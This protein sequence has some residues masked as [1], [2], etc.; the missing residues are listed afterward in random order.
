MDTSE[1]LIK[2]IPNNYKIENEIKTPK[3]FQITADFLKSIDLSSIS[4]P[5]PF[6]SITKEESNQF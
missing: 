4:I 1:E 3:D 2:G 6:I 5:L